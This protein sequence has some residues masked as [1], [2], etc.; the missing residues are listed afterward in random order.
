MSLTKPTTLVCSNSLAEDP[1]I[2]LSM[3][4]LRMKRV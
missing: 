4:A 3:T 2:E 1:I